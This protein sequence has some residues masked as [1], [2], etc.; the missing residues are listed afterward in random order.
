[1]VRLHIQIGGKVQKVFF[2]HTAKKIADVLGL[3]GWVRNVPEDSVQ[4]EVQGERIMVEQFVSF[5]LRGPRFAEVKKV[6]LEYIDVL[7]DEKAFI[8]KP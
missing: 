1:M 2:R 8:I 4:C 3:T 5:V 6:T 7:P